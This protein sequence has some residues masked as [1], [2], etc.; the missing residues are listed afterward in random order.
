[1]RVILALSVHCFCF[2]ICPS[3][4]I[5]GKLTPSQENIA[6]VSS[7]WKYLDDGPKKTS[8]LKGSL[9]NGHSCAIYTSDNTNT[10]VA[11][12]MQYGHGEIGHVYTLPAYRRRGLA[13]I[14]VRELCKAILADGLTPE[15][16]IEEGNSDPLTVYLK[17]GFV[18]SGHK[19]NFVSFSGTL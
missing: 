12:G 5:V 14:V 3:G 11:W 8:F 1:M 6:V 17:L 13:S 7:H 9:E 19:F 16:M 4:F 10:L 15:V 2:R 18:E